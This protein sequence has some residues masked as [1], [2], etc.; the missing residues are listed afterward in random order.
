MSPLIIADDDIP[1]LGIIFCVEGIQRCLC[2]LE[3]FDLMRDL[4]CDQAQGDFVS[5]PIAGD[6][7]APWL[8]SR[9]DEL[10][11]W[12]ARDRPPVPGSLPVQARA[13]M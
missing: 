3:A 5:P 6:R 4:G 1:S 2:L 7:L 10:A 13:A 11:H 12:W 8:L 9:G